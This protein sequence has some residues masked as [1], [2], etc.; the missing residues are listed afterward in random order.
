MSMNIL[1][2]ASSKYERRGRNGSKRKLKKG[3]KEEKKKMKRIRN[4]M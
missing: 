1:G 2:T 4:R 3:V